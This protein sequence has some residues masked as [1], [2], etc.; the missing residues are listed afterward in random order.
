MVWLQKRKKRKKSKRKKYIFK[1]NTHN[2]TPKVQYSPTPWVSDIQTIEYNKFEILTR[3][4]N[5]S[6]SL[7]F[8]TDQLRLNSFIALSAFEATLNTG[9]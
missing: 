5:I 7:L 1:I 6:L 8:Y 3:D 9:F 2:N 4:S